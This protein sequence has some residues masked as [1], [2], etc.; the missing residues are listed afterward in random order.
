MGSNASALPPRKK[1]ASPFSRPSWTRIASVRSGPM[2]LAKR[3]C[4]FHTRAILGLAPEDIPHARQPLL[5]GKGIH[6]VAELAAHRFAGRAPWAQGIARTSLPSCS[7]SLAKIAKPEPAKCVGHVL[8]PDRVAQVGFVAAIPLQRV[9]VSDAR[10]VGV[11]FA[12]F[13]EMFEK[14]L[15]HGL[16]G[17]KTSSC[18]YKT[19]LHVQLVEV[20]RRAVRARVFVAEAGGDLEIAVE[21]RHLDQLLELLRRLRKGVELA[22]MQARRHQKVTRP[23]GRRGGDDRRLEFGEPLI[24]HG[25]AQP[26]HTFDRSIMF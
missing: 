22:R 7:S 23:F 9:P 19:H 12:A 18:G 8:H 11:D 4:G 1:A 5:L 14:S 13:A 26:A 3:P 20:G 17:G 16:D 6:P 15:Q 10:P 25:V 21:A 2:F 24:P